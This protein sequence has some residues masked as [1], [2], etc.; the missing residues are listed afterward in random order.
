MDDAHSTT[1]HDD[2]ENVL[3]NDVFNTFYHCYMASDIWLRTI[4]I[5]VVTTWATLSD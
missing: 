3:F 1:Y 2:E 5:A 4:N